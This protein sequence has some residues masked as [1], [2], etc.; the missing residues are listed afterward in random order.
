MQFFFCNCHPTSFKWG[1]QL[2]LK[3]WLT[4]LKSD[5]G[6]RFLRRSF[7]QIDSFSPQ[8]FVWLR[9]FRRDDAAT[10]RR[11]TTGAGVM[12]LNT[13]VMNEGQDMHG[14]ISVCL[15]LPIRIPTRKTSD[16]LFL[17]S[18]TQERSLAT[19]WAQ[20]G[21]TSNRSLT[22]TPKVNAGQLVEQGGVMARKV[23]GTVVHTAH[24]VTRI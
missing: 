19:R 7:Q 18:L 8:V 24:A 15:F 3:T 17:R 23:W 14:I 13:L 22:N 9:F 2:L 10:I 6:F 11:A 16:P 20:L 1:P 12:K 5:L 21:T 4:S